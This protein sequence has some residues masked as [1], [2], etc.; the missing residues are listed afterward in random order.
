MN[1]FKI[2]L[3]AIT[4]CFSINAFAQT[5]MPAKSIELILVPV[6]S[7]SLDDLD[8]TG[9]NLISEDM[10]FNLN[11]SIQLHGDESPSGVLFQ[12][13]T[14]LGA[15]DIADENILL[16]NW[17]ENEHVLN[18]VVENHRLIMD[19][20]QVSVSGDLFC[21]LALMDSQ[22]NLTEFT[23]FPEQTISNQ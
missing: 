14:S 15:S 7:I 1:T 19:Y 22:G 12:V 21:Q 8:E 2:L 11:V 3:I 10:L 17:Q 20:G 9:E 13:G 18:L 6:S 23:F 4:L 5:I 16:D